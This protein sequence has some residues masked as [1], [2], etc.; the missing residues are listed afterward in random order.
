[1]ICKFLYFVVLFTPVQPIRA[2]FCLKSLHKNPLPRKLNRRDA[3]H[4]ESSNIKP[5]FTKRFGR[6]KN[7]SKFILTS[8]LVVFLLT[9]QP[10]AAFPPIRQAKILAQDSN[11]NPQ[12][13]EITSSFLPKISLPHPGYLSTR[14]S[15]WHPGV[16]IATGLGMPIHP[17]ADGVVE[18][19]NI[20]F[21]GYG[22]HVVISHQEKLRSLYGHMDRVY[23][24]KGQAVTDQDMLGTVGLTGRT[25]GPHTHLEITKAGSL[26]D[27][28]TVL[29]KMPDYPSEEY[30]KPYGGTG[31]PAH[32]VQPQP[33]PTAKNQETTQA[34]LNPTGTT[35]T[36]NFPFNSADRPAS[37]VLLPL[38]INQPLY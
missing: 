7:T 22:N 6:L 21:W 13:Q 36:N 31:K 38:P 2:G 11:G 28:L 5:R 9:L 27:P 30:L 18:E 24:K 33:T 14:F 25:S 16:D 12:K 37:P 32:K 34:K 26:I 19:V 35:L 1:M 23:V 3:R 15:S 8:F 4:F 17:I 29:P 10:A 20:G